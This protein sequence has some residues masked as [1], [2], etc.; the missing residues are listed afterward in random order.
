MRR[1]TSLARSFGG[2][3]SSSSRSLLFSSSSAAARSI[4]YT[5]RAAYA[6][7]AHVPQDTAAHVKTE[8]E[9]LRTYTR[10]E[11][12]KHAYE[13]DCWVII[14]EKV[15]NVSQWAD[16]HPGGRAVIY[17]VPPP[18]LFPFLPPLDFVSIA[19]APFLIVDFAGGGVVD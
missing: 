12:S 16:M 8:P 4:L 19:P 5:R 2:A 17:A 14:N 6:N 3:A 15:Y 11:V 9:K 7:D 1:S 18:P 10:D 13:D